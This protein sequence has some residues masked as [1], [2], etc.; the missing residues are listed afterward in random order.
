MGNAK[1]PKWW[2]SCKRFDV[3]APTNQPQPGHKILPRYKIA[4]AS[5]LEKGE[6]R[7]RTTICSVG[8]LDFTASC[9]EEMGYAKA[10]FQSTF[11]D[12]VRR[13]ENWC[14]SDI[15]GEFGNGNYLS[16]LCSCGFGERPNSSSPAFRRSGKTRKGRLRRVVEPYRDCQNMASDCSSN[17]K[18]SRSV[19]M[20]FMRL[21]L[22]QVSLCMYG[23]LMSRTSE[24]GETRR[25]D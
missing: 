1:D 16:N 9:S 3:Y 12:T 7:G 19:I 14:G 4:L 2:S 15:G 24:Y 11:V 22:C 20:T 23:K 17:R 21:G 18:V 25:I 6:Q 8:Q 10:T 13:I 5:I